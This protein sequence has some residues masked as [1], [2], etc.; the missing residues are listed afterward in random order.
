MFDVIVL[1]AIYPGPAWID[2][3][4]SEWS[5]TI[6][7]GSNVL[8]LAHLWPVQPWTVPF[9][10][11]SPLS[12]VAV[13]IF[14]IT[15][16]WVI[17][18]TRR[19]NKREVFQW[20]SDG[21][22]VYLPATIIYGDQGHLSFLDSI[23]PTFKNGAYRFGQGTYLVEATGN[24][25]N[26]YTLG[27][28]VFEL[29]FFLLAHAWCSLF[30]PSDADGYSPPYHLAIAISSAVWAWLGLLVLMRWLRR[31]L[32]D[33]ATALSLL[34]LGLG[35]NLFFYSSYASGMAHPHL[36]FLCAVLI[37]RTAKWHSVPTWKAAFA[38]GL[39]IG[40]AALTR[41]TCV[42]FALIP[43]CWRLK[44]G[45]EGESSVTLFRAHGL[46]L[47]L[48]LTIATICVLPQVLFWKVTSGH[49]LFYS[50]GGE[51]F[52]FAD[53]HILEGLLGFRKGWFVYSPLVLLGIAGLILMSRDL[54]ARSYVL[55]AALFLI[56]FVF[57]T[58]SWQA[59]WYGGGFGSRVMIETLP[60][61]A[62]PLGILVQKCID[63]SHTMALVLGVV[64]LL[65]IG[66]NLFQQWQ[67]LHG[68]MH[69]EN[70]DR[71]LYWKIFLAPSHEA[72][73][74]PLDQ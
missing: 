54:K 39:C 13:C 34:A 40:L 32:S 46:H 66:L 9:F 26:K 7:A 68:I 18:N 57:V 53:P 72:A 19:W 59:W 4:P 6:H 22:Y 38:I 8:G 51:G 37:E 1:V 23:P 27:T 21:Y 24:M 3:S 62:L 67:Y 33:R 47:L 14:F 30:S 29:P 17:F 48:A 60:V 15:A 74:I 20:D 35:T 25:C 73:G 65:G 10:R 70:M 58:F 11:R 36:F 28:A 12:T 42:L 55:M 52:D 5:R 56:P 45:V 2:W 44:A 43:L 41:P 31:Y 49:Y 69:F 71:E 64:V 61:I 63:R 16:V 50:Y